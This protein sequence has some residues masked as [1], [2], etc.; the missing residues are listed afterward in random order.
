MAAFALIINLRVADC[1]LESRILSS[2][3]S[4]VIQNADDRIKNR[5][6]KSLF[7]LGF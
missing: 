5:F 4:P 3:V 2:L 7:K 6:W 1:K